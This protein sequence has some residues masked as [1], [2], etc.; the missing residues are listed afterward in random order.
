MPKT[1]YFQQTA[2][3]IN[4]SI[5]VNL[6]CDLRLNAKTSITA[7]TI[8]PLSKLLSIAKTVDNTIKNGIVHNKSVIIRPVFILRF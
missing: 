2:K 8:T 7:F 3:Q 5:T 4:Q 1:K 6:K